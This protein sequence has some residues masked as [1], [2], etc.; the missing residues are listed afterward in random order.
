[1]EKP[2]LA[3]IDIGTNSFHLIIVEVDTIR[4]LQHTWAREGR[5]TATA[6]LTDMKHLGNDAMNRGIEALKKFSALAESASTR[7]GYSNKRS[8][9]SCESA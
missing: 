8:E 5:S 4:Q 1:M 6:S 3:A 9:R 7:A 2:R